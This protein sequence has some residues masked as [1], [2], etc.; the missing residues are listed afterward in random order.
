MSNGPN[1]IERYN[2][3]FDMKQILFEILC[4]MRLYVKCLIWYNNFHLYFDSKIKLKIFGE[5]IKKVVDIKRL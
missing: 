3:D 4:T 2:A 5:K 1:F